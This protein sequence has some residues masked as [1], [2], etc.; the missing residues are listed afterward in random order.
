MINLDPSLL[1]RDK[2]RKEQR[3]HL[4]RLCL[5]P[6]IILLVVSLFFLSS[7]FY[8]LIY[9]VSY[10]NNNFP[11]AHDITETRFLMNILEPYIPDYNQGVALM[12]VGEFK[13]AEQS[14]E[15]SIE[16][17][18]PADR[19]CKVYENLSLSIE[20]QADRA[21]IGGQYGSAIELYSYAQ[22]VLLSSGCAGEG[23]TDGK[24]YNSDIAKYRISESKK[25]AVDEMNNTPDDADSS[26]DPAREKEVTEK[27]M[28]SIDEG[29]VSPNSAQGLSR[30]KGN[31]SAETCHP[32]NGDKCW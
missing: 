1:D 5:A 30:F 2:V 29:N 17:N 21:K 28:D 18:P 14:F 23:D 13:K 24:S 9:F 3:K 11:I 26:L 16:N 19:I 25:D 7:W 10:S 31:A 8:N 12:R 6:M 22:S 27:D 4:L 15:K 20:K 32:N